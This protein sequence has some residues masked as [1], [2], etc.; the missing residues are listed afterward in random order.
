MEVSS[1]SLIL[2]HSMELNHQ[3][4][5]HLLMCPQFVSYVVNLMPLALLR[6]KFRNFP[7]ELY[8]G[9]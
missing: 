5:E 3:T 1:L 4:A 6:G 8:S 2:S 7:L 9:H